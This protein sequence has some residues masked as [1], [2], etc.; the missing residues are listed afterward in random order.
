MNFNI[1]WNKQWKKIVV[2]VEEKKTTKSIQIADIITADV[3]NLNTQ[4][5]II[6]TTRWKIANKI[7][8]YSR[9]SH[10][11]YIWFETD[12]IELWVSVAVLMPVLA[13]ISELN[14]L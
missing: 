5:L 8:I 9:S 10:F 2:C 11:D 6:R 4:H 12:S 13:S 1:V 7:D 3:L 14:S